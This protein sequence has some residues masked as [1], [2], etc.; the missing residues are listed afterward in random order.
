MS[1]TV[2]LGTWS[3][4]AVGDGNC[5]E[6]IKTDGWVCR[7]SLVDRAAPVGEISIGQSVNC[8]RRSDDVDL[9]VAR[10][11]TSDLEGAEVGESINVGDLDGIVVLGK[12][13][14]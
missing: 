10:E 12:R 1:I 4:N 8:W 14:V 2:V 6:T 7:E 9:V 13:E 11:L 3:N 5:L